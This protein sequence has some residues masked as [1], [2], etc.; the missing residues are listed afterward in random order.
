MLLT[1]L[2][3][4][5]FQK[6]RIFLYPALGIKRGISVTPIETYMLWDNHYV[7][8][9]CR[10]ICTYY[11]RD[12]SEFRIFEETFLLGNKYYDNFYELSDKIGAYVFDLTP[13]REDYLKIVNGKYSK[14]SKTHKT[15]ISNFFQNHKNHHLYIQSYLYPNMFMANYA[16][17][18]NVNVR[19]LMELGELCSLPDLIKETFVFSEKSSNFEQNNLTNIQNYGKQ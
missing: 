9:D 7:I 15:S 11:I 18:L 17:L 8:D 14:L 1:S 12:D 19:V 3:S 6:S 5:Y 10:L 16:E 4:D 13:I 2:K